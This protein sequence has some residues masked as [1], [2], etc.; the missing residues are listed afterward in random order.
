MY[1]DD[2]RVGPWRFYDTTGVLVK[3][4]NF[5]LVPRMP[6]GDSLK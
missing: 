6:E 4:V 1:R 3:E 5:D 2:M